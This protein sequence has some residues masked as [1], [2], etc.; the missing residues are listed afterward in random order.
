MYVC[1]YVCIYT[2]SGLSGKQN[3]QLNVTVKTEVYTVCVC[4]AVTTG[5]VAALF[6]FS[7]LFQTDYTVAS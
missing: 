6:K 5:W 7:V 4:E 3:T 1:M 2:E